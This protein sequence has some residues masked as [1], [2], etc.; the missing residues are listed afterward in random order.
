MSKNRCGN[1]SPASRS[2]SR[3]THCTSVL[4]INSAGWV[5][6]MHGATATICLLHNITHNLCKQKEGKRQTQQFFQPVDSSLFNP[7]LSSHFTLSGKCCSSTLDRHRLMNRV[8]QVGCWPTGTPRH[9][10]EMFQFQALH[11]CHGTQ[12]PRVIKKTR[13][14]LWQ[15]N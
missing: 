2:D 9:Q 6:T 1:A 15:L 12:A 7:N 11:Y 3:C 8:A 13:W 14:E 4:V 10:L 5:F